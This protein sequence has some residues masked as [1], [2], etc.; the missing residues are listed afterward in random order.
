MTHAPPAWHPDPPGEHDLRYWDGSAWTD[1][2]ASAD[3]VIDDSIGSDNS[4][5][6]PAPTLPP[7]H[8]A[9]RG[10]RMPGSNPRPPKL[11][12]NVGSV[13]PDRWS[14]LELAGGVLFFVS[15]VLA[16]LATFAGQDGT[17]LETKANMVVLFLWMVPMGLLVALIGFIGYEIARSRPVDNARDR[18]L[19]VQF[20]DGFD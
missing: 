4:D 18:S 20:G 9:S 11:N 7:S 15:P 17:D 8:P 14:K 3:E 5:Y 19:F 12:A 1:R 2:V 13:W 16:F 10:V 6:G